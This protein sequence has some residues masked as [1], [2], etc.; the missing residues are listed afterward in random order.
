MRIKSSRRFFFSCNKN[1][2]DSFSPPPSILLLL[3]LYAPGQRVR[4]R[5]FWSGDWQLVWYQLR[6]VVLPQKLFNSLH[7]FLSSP[8]NRI[9]SPPSNCGL[10]WRGRLSL[11]CPK[12]QHLVQNRLAATYI[13][14][15]PLPLPPS[16]SSY[17]WESHWSGEWD[18]WRRRRLWW[19]LSPIPQAQC[20][21]NSF[22]FPA[23]T[24]T[25]ILTN[26]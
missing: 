25:S 22:F 5:R 17:L 18:I 7:L 11:I 13:I 24:I 16:S 15:A 12:Y 20:S 3:L 8:P 14:F 4:R 21:G 23:N 26:M 1:S 19:R 10:L 2:D 9:S 6:S